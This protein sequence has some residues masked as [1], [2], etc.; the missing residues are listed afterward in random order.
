MTKELILFQ[1]NHIT[2]RA[3][4]A[5]RLRDLA[6]KIEA[7]S[8]KLGDHAITLPDQVHLFIELG[9]E[10][11]EGELELEIIWPAWDKMGPSGLAAR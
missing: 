6:D 5:D 11:D 2:T 9:T 4:A 1:E 8:F 10:E 3:A 7:M